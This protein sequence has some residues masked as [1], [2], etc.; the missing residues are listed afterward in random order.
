MIWKGVL[1]G[2]DGRIEQKRKKRTHGYGK[3]G[4]D[5]GGWVKEEEG[6]EG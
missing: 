3:Q 6:I 4:A 1:G 5:K 2:S